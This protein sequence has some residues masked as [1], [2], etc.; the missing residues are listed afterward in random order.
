MAYIWDNV[1]PAS[2]KSISLLRPALSLADPLAALALPAPPLPDT[3][4]PCQVIRHH[5][6]GRFVGDC[7]L[8]DDAN[9]RLRKLDP[10]RPAWTVAYTLA[11][12]YRGRGVVKAALAAVMSA[13][14]QWVGIE[15]VLGVSTLSE[16]SLMPR[17]Q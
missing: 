3:L 16:R 17:C 6:T 15:E 7:V 14:V 11:P 2:D 5:P 10:T 13:W 4:F 12:E 1:V 8:F 9:A